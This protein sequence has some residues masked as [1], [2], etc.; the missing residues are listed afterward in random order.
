MQSKNW[1]LIDR[2]IFAKVCKNVYTIKNTKPWRHSF[3]PFSQLLSTSLR[4]LFRFVSL[5]LFKDEKC[6]CARLMKSIGRQSLL[7]PENTACPN[8][9]RQT[10]K[11]KKSMF[12]KANPTFSS[13]FFVLGLLNYLCI[14]LTFITASARLVLHANI[15]HWY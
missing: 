13:K 8:C 14:F 6:S 2:L 4:F 3:S 12:G 1:T 11:Y 15:D 10:I 7:L 9:N 5:C